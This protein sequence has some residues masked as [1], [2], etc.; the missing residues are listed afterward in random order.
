MWWA[1]LAGAAILSMVIYKLAKPKPTVWSAL[2]FVQEASE[3][4]PLWAD[5]IDT[6]IRQKGLKVWYTALGNLPA[7]LWPFVHHHIRDTQFILEMEDTLLELFPDTHD[8]LEELLEE[9]TSDTDKASL[10]LAVLSTLHNRLEYGNRD[11]VMYAHFSK[12]IKLNRLLFCSPCLLPCRP[13]FIK[14]EA[15]LNSQC[16]NHATE[17]LMAAST[18]RHAKAASP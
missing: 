6:L 7:N 13:T 15:L 18:L 10:R 16:A 8:L 9:Q 17:A 3:H 2:E 1:L 11:S 4:T 14:C 5:S 12:Q